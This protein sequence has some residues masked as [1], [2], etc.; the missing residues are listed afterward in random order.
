MV[1]MVMMFFARGLQ[2][3]KFLVAAAPGRAQLFFG[4]A[5]GIGPSLCP[6]PESFDD[7]VRR[8]N[9]HPAPSTMSNEEQQEELDVLQAIYDQELTRTL[10]AP[11]SRAPQL[12]PK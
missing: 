8:Q 4:G 10:P 5:A 11:P 9:P 7:H 6:A 1:E 12:T 3:G 2:A